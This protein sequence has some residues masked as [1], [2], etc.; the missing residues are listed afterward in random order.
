[1]ASGNAELLIG[2]LEVAFDGT[3]RELH[4]AGDLLVG[5]AY[6][7]LHGGVELA[8]SQP[9]PRS[10]GSEWG[11]GGAFA[12]GQ[13]SRGFL[14]R[15]G[16]LPGHAGATEHDGGFGA[17]FGGVEVGAEVLELAGDLVERRAVSGRDS[18]GVSGASRRQITVDLVRS[19]PLPASAQLL[20]RNGQVRSVSSCDALSILTLLVTPYAFGLLRNEVSSTSRK[21]SLSC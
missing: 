19:T 9:H 10:H 5:A 6:R 20:L 21:S 11:G 13:Q 4:V 8:W 3:D 17:C 14:L 1:V 16:R 2:A 15:G 7:G 18:A 12:A